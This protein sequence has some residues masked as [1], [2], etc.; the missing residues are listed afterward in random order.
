[1]SR[2]LLSV[3]V[4]TLRRAD[5][6]R[7]TLATLTAQSR[8]D[9][10]IVVQNNGDDDEV[11]AVV[12][13]AG[14]GRVS[15]HASAE[16]LPMVANWE[17][18]LANTTGKFITFIGD[19]DGLLPD[20]AELAADVLGTDEVEVLS[21]EPLLYRWPMFYDP[22]QRNRLE[23]LVEF[24]PELTQV[25]TLPLLQRFYR[26]EEHYA[27]LPMI[28]NSFVARALVERVRSG[29]GHYFFGSL[30]DVSSG[31]VDAA[32][33]EMFTRSGRPLSVAGLSHHSIGHRL[34]RAGA[35]PSASDMARDF[36]ELI[37]DEELVAGGNLE[38]MIA[39]DMR[40][41]ATSVLAGLVDVELDEQGLLDAMVAAVNDAPDRFE[42]TVAA[43]RGRAELLGLNP[44]S[45]R[46][47]ERL[48]HPPAPATGVHV[49]GPYEVLFVLDGDELGL[50]S[51]ADAAKLGAQLLPPRT[52]LVSAA[53]ARVE[54]APILSR[55]PLALTIGGPGV[56][57]LDRGWGEPEAWGV[58][59]V[60]REAVLRL[61][62]PGGKRRRIEI[63]YRSIPFPDG[64]PRT[65]SCRLGEKTIGRWTFD[66][67][68]HAGA[69]VINLP[70]DARAGELELVFVNENARSP[71]ELG[72]SDDDRPLGIGLEQ[73]RL[74]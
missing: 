33:C 34:T 72:L 40:A 44:D 51:I 41:V 66:R 45:V 2:P 47:P 1:M 8:D 13:M 16:V 60:G 63:R 7:H 38:L 30:P 68:R 59:S 36:P 65:V 14:D 71:A 53:T 24:A 4:P 31:I 23:A 9:L 56:S 42:A 35:K 69:I 54:H 25:R 3:V 29:H 22:P 18:A 5:T 50:A 37:S 21:W 74:A 70:A 49:R 43:I 11:K 62:L 61:R 52:G 64:D 73:I 12:A 15:H 26:F 20:A 46:I 48:E 6:L 10:E 28:Y 32:Y 67:S 55:E 39:A 27:K 57:A 19:D 17:L 58:W